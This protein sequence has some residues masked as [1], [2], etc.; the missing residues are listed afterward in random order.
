MCIS[1]TQLK[2]K[3]MVEWRKVYLNMA[4][5]YGLYRPPLLLNPVNQNQNNIKL[6]KFLS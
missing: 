3:N 2:L 6:T 4:W 1:L 5:I